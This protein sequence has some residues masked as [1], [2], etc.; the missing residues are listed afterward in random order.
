MNTIK[1]KRSL[2]GIG[3]KGDGI[4]VCY[5]YIWMPVLT[6]CFMNGTMNPKN[7]RYE[8]PDTYVI[9]FSDIVDNNIN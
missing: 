6:Y 8:I 3:L 9:L 5:T 2:K 7:N 1:L 4:V